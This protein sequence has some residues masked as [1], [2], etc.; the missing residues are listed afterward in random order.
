MARHEYG[1]LL[2]HIFTEIHRLRKQWV[3]KVV[4]KYARRERKQW[5][6]RWNPWFTT[7]YSISRVGNHA[8]RAPWII[9]WALEFAIR[10]LHVGGSTNSLAERSV[11][12]KWA[13]DE[14]RYYCSLN[15][16]CLTIIPCVSKEVENEQWRKVNFK[17]LEKY[18]YEYWFSYCSYRYEYTYRYVVAA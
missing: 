18:R 6:Y 8:T 17:I 14:R 12:F 13:R 3:S 5:S 1:I 16:P 7:L 11:R 9:R 2:Y 15:A 10:I 4:M